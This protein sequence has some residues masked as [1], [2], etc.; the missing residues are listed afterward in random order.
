MQIIDDFDEAFFNT[1]EKHPDYDKQVFCSLLA[2]REYGA[3]Y[4][5]R[6]KRNK[7]ASYDQ[8]DYISSIALMAVKIGIS[9]E[10]C[11]SKHPDQLQFLPYGEEC[12]K[13]YLAV[14]AKEIDPISYLTTHPQLLTVLANAYATYRYQDNGMRN[15]RLPKVNIPTGISLISE[16]LKKAKSINKITYNEANINKCLEDIR[17][18]SQ[19]THKRSEYALDGELFAVSDVGRN[20]R[21]GQQ[22]SVLIMKHPNNSEFRLLS[23]CDGVGGSLR[24]DWASSFTVL[25][26]S[27]WFESI[28]P[29]MFEKEE[30]LQIMLNKKLEAINNAIYSNKD[31]PD[32]QSTLTCTIVCKNK[33][34]VCSIG[35]SRIYSIKDSALNQESTDDSLVEYL[36]SQNE[37]PSKEDMRFH[38]KS[39]VITACLGQEH[40]KSKSKIISNS[41]YDTL[42]LLSDGVSDCLSDD[43]IRFYST[44]TPKSLI[45]KELVDKALI[46]TSHR[47]YS[48]DEY[49]TEIPGGKDNTTA[50]VY[51]KE[52]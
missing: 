17:Q 26:L 42:I 36:R 33:T 37:I 34:I 48:G 45:A 16:S 47:E 9:Y 39:N 11:E 12:K 6:E 44:S 27:E 20:E 40:L 14:Y 35:D 22:D 24:G 18:G 43:L 10:Y 25:Q 23:V 51:V 15:A 5:S 8:L 3:K 2:T 50:A 13:F 1:F 52:R 38:R 4:F 30:E 32:S 49:Y 28:K 7:I 19:V 21:K 46:T 41:S 31:Y 29:E